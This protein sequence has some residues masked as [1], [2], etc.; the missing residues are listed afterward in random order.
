MTWVSYGSRDDLF[1]GLAET[2]TRELE[3]ALAERANV[4]LAVPGGTTPGPMFDILAQQDFAWSQ[5]TVLLSDERWVPQD[6]ERSNAALLYN[7]LFVANGASARFLGFFE[8]GDIALQIAQKAKQIEAHLPLDVLVLGMGADMHTASLFP[9]APELSKALAKDSPPLV[10]LQPAD[11]PEL[12]VS[13][14]GSVLA[15]ARSKHLLITGAEKKA[16]FEAAQER[17]V[18]QAPIKVAMDGLTVHWAE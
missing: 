8:E 10:A 3:N 9:G 18:Q 12:R 11:Q 16:A 13:L 2:V 4:T 1:A 7:R 14:S 5:V 15:G 6:H 17:S